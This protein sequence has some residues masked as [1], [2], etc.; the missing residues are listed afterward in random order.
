MGGVW[1]EREQRQGGVIDQ[2]FFNPTL[3]RPKAGIAQG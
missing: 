1:L 3:P 2:A